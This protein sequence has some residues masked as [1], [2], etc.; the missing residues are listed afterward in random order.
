MQNQNNEN[1][2]QKN[3]SKWALF[4]QKLVNEQNIDINFGNGPWKVQ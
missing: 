4:L 2:I 1:E 3:L